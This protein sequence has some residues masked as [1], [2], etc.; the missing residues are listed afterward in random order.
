MGGTPP[1]VSF[2]GQEFILTGDA[3][4]EFDDGIAVNPAGNADGSV[5]E[6]YEVN[7]GQ[8]TGVVVACTAAQYDQ[9]VELKNTVGFKDMSIELVTGEKYVSRSGAKPLNVKFNPAEETATFD[10]S[11]DR[12]DRTGAWLKR[13]S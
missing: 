13:L 8:I 9:L 6:L 4:P 12:P 10:I 7:P 1:A 2:A 3:K 5:R 11:G